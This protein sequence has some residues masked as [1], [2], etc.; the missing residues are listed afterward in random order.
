[1]PA[2]SALADPTHAVFG[3]ELAKNLALL[4]RA[5]RLPRNR[6]VVTRNF[7]AA[8][9]EAALLFVDGLVSR[10]ALQQHVLRPCMER[11]EALGAPPQDA[12]SELARQTLTASDAQQVTDADEAI[13][14]LLAG[15]GLLLMDG[16]PAALLIDARAPARRGVDKPVNE[17]V[18]LGPQEGFVENLR[19]NLALV[20][21]GMRSPR[22]VTETVALGQGAPTQCAVLY[23][24]GVAQADVV[25]EVL[26][27]VRGVAMDYVP[28][29][30][31]LEQLIEDHPWALFPQICATER[32]DRACSFLVEGQVLVFVD[33]SPTALGM[34]ATL[35]HLIHTADDTYMRWQYGSFLRLIRTLGMYVAMWLPGAYLAL[36]Q[37]HQQAFPP[38]LLVSVYEAQ[39]RMPMPLVTEALLMLLAFHLINEAGL[40]V[41]GSLGSSLG[42]ISALILGQAAVA[43]DLV[44]PLMIIVA[45]M[46]G[47]GSFVVPDYSMSLAIKLR[48]ILYLLVANWM[49]AYGMLMLFLVLHT[50]LC[51]MTSMGVPF[52]G[53]ISPARPHNPD[54]LLRLPLWLQ[55]RRAFFADA[56]HMART[57]G[58]VRRWRVK[59]GRP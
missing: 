20:R 28:G 49:G 27:R 57:R 26:R 16:C 30:G 18:V 46:A 39:S 13:V 31:Q 9:A 51:M 45:A 58:A 8:G 7:V 12:L 10:D 38:V 14:G 48:Q 32:P 15:K 59:G 25:A 17:S 19:T 35:Q 41:P 52:M 36:V 22:L 44:S 23:L 5:L 29:A 1:M 4:G 50:R 37:H 34:P 6:D 47:L 53:P 3:P 11:T 33:G 43:A 21:S 55:K 40:R 2:H 56:R 42:V 54:L 24:D